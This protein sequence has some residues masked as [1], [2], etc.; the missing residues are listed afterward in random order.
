MKFPVTGF[1]AGKGGSDQPPAAVNNGYVKVN[2][3]GINTGKM[4]FPFLPVGA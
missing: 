3:Y 1:I 4:K 2:G